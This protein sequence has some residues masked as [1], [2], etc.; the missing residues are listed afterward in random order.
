MFNILIA[1]QNVKKRNELLH[2]L[3]DSY[4][5]ILPSDIDY[6]DNV[7][8]TETSF[9]GNAR[10]KAQALHHFALSKGIQAAIIADDSGLEVEAL[11]GEPG[12]HSAR[13]AGVHQN[14]NDNTQLL[15]LKLKGITHRK[16]RFVSVIIYQFLKETHVFRG[17][18]QGTIAYQARGINGFGYDAVFIP[19]GFRSTF[20]ELNPDQK[21]LISHRA[22]AM[23]SLVDF[24]KQ[25]AK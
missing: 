11:K 6:T 22:Q 13:Y 18:V 5:V 7:E 17:E 23:K 4:N 16:A 9:E 1:S 15:L 19:R 24:I 21:N 10:L 20:A 25:S 3:P 2:L 12:V 14:D 8:E